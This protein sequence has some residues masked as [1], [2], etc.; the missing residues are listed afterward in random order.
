[1]ILQKGQRRGCLASLSENRPA[2][3]YVSSI[4]ENKLIVSFLIVLLLATVFIRYAEPTRDTDLF[5]QMNYGK[6]I[7]ENHTLRPD[8]A[9]Y[10][11]TPVDKEWVYVAWIGEVF[12]YVLYS[13][14]GLTLLFIFKYACLLIVLACLSIFSIKT[15]A[16]PVQFN[17][18]I[19]MLT[20]VG[21]Y[22]GVYLKPEIFSLVFITI[23]VVIFYFAKAFNR[24]KLFYLFPILM[25]IW[26]NTHGGSVFGLLFMASILIGETI[27]FLFSQRS[28]LTKASYKI[29]V[30]SSVAALCVI[31][32]NP[33]GYNHI[34]M[35]VSQIA[36][37]AR[38]PNGIESQS[39]YIPIFKSGTWYP[40]YL[41]VMTP[42]AIGLLTYLFVKKREL[43][44]SV[45]LLNILFSLIY[46]MYLRSTYLWPP[47]WYATIVYLLYRIYGGRIPERIKGKAFLGSVFAISFIVLSVL[48]I[49]RSIYYPIG[50]S[51][52]F[53]FGYGYMCPVEEA[54]YIEKH[55]SDK[56]ILNDYGIGGY[57]NWRFYPSIKIFLDPR[58]GPF[59]KTGVYEDYRKFEVGRTFKQFID[60]YGFDVAIMRFKYRNAVRNL[61]ASPGWQVAYYGK[62]AVVFI[63][64]GS[65]STPE[66]TYKTE[67]VSRFDDLKN[68]LQARKVLLF[69][70]SI[71]DFKVSER[72]ITLMRNKFYYGKFK[73]DICQ[74]SSF[75]NAVQTRD[76]SPFF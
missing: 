42:M 48:T 65:V 49:F 23:S 24:T 12:L 36:E 52:W 72:V 56:R 15:K 75:Y 28:A 40:Y 5:W 59:V 39:A 22:S 11:W 70:L 67:P 46:V 51:T 19:L 61:I 1:M 66:E 7:V 74:L 16:V 17:L 20:M 26:V 64:K 73:S 41:F 3:F 34:I 37:A 57:L 60:K 4:L 30:I 45:I 29:L 25:L 31:V 9:L 58:Y 21:I 54:N 10:S 33:H 27:N 68:F 32:I 47:I 44:F 18:F 76:P 53:G 14:G 62:V 13:L 71:R 69:S 43:D 2:Y 6:Y 38:D 50:L 55:F 35:T 63:K 8:H